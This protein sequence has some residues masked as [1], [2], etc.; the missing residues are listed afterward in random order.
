MKDEQLKV[1]DSTHIHVFGNGRRAYFRH[2]FAAVKYAVIFAGTAIIMIVHAF[3]PFFLVNVGSLVVKRLH[4]M[5]NLC[6]C[7]K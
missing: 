6:K 2:L 3:L 4:H 5:M 1:F 7:K